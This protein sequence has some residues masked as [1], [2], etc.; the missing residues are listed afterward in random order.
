MQP[1]RI[2]LLPSII[3]A[4]L[5]I[6]GTV[7]TLCKPHQYHIYTNLTNRI[8]CVIKIKFIYDTVHRGSLRGKKNSIGFY[9]SML[10]FYY[11]I[12]DRH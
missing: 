4:D 6:S 1:K 12:N 5:I 3:T 10:L 8:D 11:F 2:Q 9:R 7:I